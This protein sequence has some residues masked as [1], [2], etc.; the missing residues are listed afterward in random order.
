MRSIYLNMKRII[1]KYNVYNMYTILITF[2]I[3]YNLIILYLNMILSLSLSLSLSPATLLVRIHGFPKIHGILILDSIAH[4]TRN[5]WRYNLHDQ[6]IE[7]FFSRQFVQRRKW[8]SVVKCSNLLEGFRRIAIIKF[9]STSPSSLA[10]SLP[11]ML[12][13]IMHILC[14]R[15]ILS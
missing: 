13:Y 6:Y 3:L 10:I 2:I 11:S 14:I 4:E 9:Y 5:K 8:D 15:L 12:H 1:F 7:S